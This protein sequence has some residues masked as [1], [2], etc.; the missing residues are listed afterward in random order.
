MQQDAMAAA[1]ERALQGG[2]DTE[3]KRIHRKGRVRVHSAKSA[4]RQNAAK[5][6]A[7]REE[8][9]R[10]QRESGST[11]QQAATLFCYIVLITGLAQWSRCSAR[12]SAWRFLRT[13][14]STRHSRG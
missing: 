7:Q 8:N 9:V 4:C 14:G 10:R 2:K 12:F 6:R 1:R 3:P 11:K 13:Q 5:A